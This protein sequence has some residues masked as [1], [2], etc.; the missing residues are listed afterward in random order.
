MNQGRQRWGGALVRTIRGT[1]TQSGEVR[2]RFRL[3]CS[4]V[5]RPSASVLAMQ[6]DP[7]VDELLASV[8]AHWRD[9]GPLEEIL[10]TIDRVWATDLARHEPQ[11]GDDATSLGIQCSRNVMNLVARSGTIREIDGCRVRG[12]NTLTVSF[13]TQVLHTSKVGRLGRRWDPY[14]MD[15]NSSDTRA[16][17]AAANSRAYVPASGTLFEGLDDGPSGDPAAL[18]YVHLAWQG[19]AEGRTRVFM[20]FPSEGHSPWMAVHLLADGQSG[21]GGRVP[22]PEAGPS[23]PNHDVMAEPTVVVKRRRDEAQASA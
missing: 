22:Q 7:V 6:S 5:D 19:L 9:E 10:A 15:W 3:I 12:G 14:S 4:Q 11:L 1:R 20:G 13:A 16:D 17:G 8:I 21:G 2:P 18:R 23:T